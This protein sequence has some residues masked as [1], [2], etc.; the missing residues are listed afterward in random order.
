LERVDQARKNGPD[1]AVRA[2]TIGAIEPLAPTADDHRTPPG[3]N[4][5]AST[6]IIDQIGGMDDTKHN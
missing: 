3:V 4:R 5:T 2:G 6:D 1:I